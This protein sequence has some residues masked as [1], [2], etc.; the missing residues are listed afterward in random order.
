MG[1]SQS[2]THTV[3]I[4]NDDLS[5]IQVSKAVA[6]RLTRGMQKNESSAS[7]KTDKK[8]PESVKPVQ[9][10]IPTSA[11]QTQFIS[12][13]DIQK[14]VHNAIEENNKY[15]SDQV[16]KI[17]VTNNETTNVMKKEHE[18]TLKEIE[19]I[20]PP[21]PKEKKQVSCVDVKDKVLKCYQS[22]SKQSLK[23]LN[24]VNQ[25]TACILDAKA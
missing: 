6:D 9:Y 24:E 2:S 22:N 10:N 17:I 19:S 15:W 7:S 14:H 23:C 12:S 8:A 5:T 13:L 25:F 4:D 18:K 21:V 20:L 16:K 3:T 1:S 11:V